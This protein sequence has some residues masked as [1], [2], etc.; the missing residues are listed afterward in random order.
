MV[1]V[2]E[3]LFVSTLFYS[4]YFFSVLTQKR[5][6]LSLSD[7]LFSELVRQPTWSTPEI[8]NI[9]NALHHKLM[10][11]ILTIIFI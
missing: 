3:I 5:A 8:S 1:R 7:D 11:D 9:K 4:D 6:P 2:I 10:K